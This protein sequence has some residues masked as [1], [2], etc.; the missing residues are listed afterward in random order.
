[1][2]SLP[3]SWHVSLSASSLGRCASSGETPSCSGWSLPE[4]R[5]REVESGGCPIRFSRSAPAKI[6]ALRKEAKNDSAGHLDDIRRRRGLVERLANEEPD[7]RGRLAPARSRLPN[8]VCRAARLSD[9]PRDPIHL[10]A[11]EIAIAPFA[12][13]APSVTFAFDHS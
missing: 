1:M 7:S 12:Y 11:S 10:P 13:W 3:T 9:C 4:R 5:A 2:K 8:A 6:D